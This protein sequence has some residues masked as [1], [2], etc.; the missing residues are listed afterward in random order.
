MEQ[1]IRSLP[2]ASRPPRTSNAT[3]RNGT[4]NART[5][6]SSQLNQ[7]SQ[8]LQLNAEIGTLKQQMTEMREMLR[9]TMEMQMDTQR[10]IRQEVS[11][12]F[13][14]FMQQMSEG[15]DSHSTFASLHLIYIVVIRNGSNLSKY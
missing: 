14:A 7:R 6:F 15:I 12:V 1:F 9:M 3:P 13:G 4:A 5:S 8:N 2:S 10:A 11:A